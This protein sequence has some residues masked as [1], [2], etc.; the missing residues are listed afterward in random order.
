MET[1]VVEIV[2]MPNVFT[3]IGLFQMKRWGRYLALILGAI[4]LISGLIGLLFIIGVIPFAFGLA[5]VLYPLF[6]VA[7]QVE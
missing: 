7:P 2:G 3:A 4:M 5:A 6:Y 1:V